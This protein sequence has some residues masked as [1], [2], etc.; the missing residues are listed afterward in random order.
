LSRSDHI[1]CTSQFGR[2]FRSNGR[3]RIR[4]L[5]VASQYAWP[6]SS[7]HMAH[8]ACCGKFFFVHYMQ[9][10][11]QSRLCK[12]DHAYPVYYYN[13]CLDIWT[14]VTLKAVKFKQLIFS[15][16]GFYLSYPANIFLFHNFVW[17]LLAAC[18]ILAYNRIHTEV[19][20]PCAKS[21]PRCTLENFQ[22]CAEPCFIGAVILREKRL[23]QI[24]RRGKHKS[25]LK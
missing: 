22:W 5:G 15:M 9:V 1:L 2:L 10:L 24:P 20:K 21:A 19:W 8:V 25:L 7:V 18:T 11:C 16:S 12:G 3:R 6:F 4:L 23:P 14:V 17:P 13:G